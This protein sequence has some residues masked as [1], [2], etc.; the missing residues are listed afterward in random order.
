MERSPFLAAQIGLDDADWRRVWELVEYCESSP[1][2]QAALVNPPLSDRTPR[3]GRAPALQWAPLAKWKRERARRITEMQY[4]REVDWLS[5][6]ARN[7]PD[8]PDFNWR[9]PLDLKAAPIP[10]WADGERFA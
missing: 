7:K 2:Q 4:Q 5:W 8:H 3:N 9:K 6:A 10:K 1:E